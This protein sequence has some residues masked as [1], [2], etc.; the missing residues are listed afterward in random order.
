MA[1]KHHLWIPG[2]ELPLIRPHSLAKHRVIEAYLKRY[3]EVL[4]ANPRQPEFCLTLVDG[5]AGGGLYRDSQTKERRYGSPLLMLHA[6]KEAAQN[7]QKQR[8]KEFHLDVEYFFIEN[9]QGAY[10][11]LAAALQDT[12]FRSL[13]DDKIKLIH[14]E[15]V[16]QV[17]PIVERVEQRG[18][19]KR[20][21]FV[22]DQFGYSDVPMPALR[23]ILSQLDN[24][25]IILTFASDSLINYLS[26][27]ETFQ[28]ILERLGVEISRGTITTL[29]QE[30][31]W[32]RAI[33]DILHREIHQRSE[34]KYYTPFFIRSTDA[35]RDFWLIHL[36]GHARAR[37]VMVG[38]H[39]SE[40][41]SFAHYGRPGLH[42]LGYDP[43]AD[44][45]LTRQ[46]S[47]PV[48]CFDDT[49]RGLSI[50]AL[51]DQLP[52]RISR[53]SDGLPFAEFFA[54]TTNE[55]PATSEIMKEAIATLCREGIV[56]VTD[57]TGI[58]R[59]KVGVQSNSDVLRLSRQKRFITR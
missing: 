20:V 53:H 1:D 45:K 55:T 31:N 19:G 5:F 52:Q 9:D 37:D 13:V 12:E 44:A 23:Q 26:S 8:L 18:R 22:L 48:F 59:R 34:A 47:L 57:K 51:L 41:N 32:R 28:R 39:W 58:K 4:T 46:S 27:N 25:E 15:F 10:Q 36:S 14:G 56:N 43:A 3:V 42:M 7:A 38:L 35:H 11:C 21:I 40:N 2:E 50:D 17:D 30:R 6:M 49:A 29:K 54:A 33:Q 16:S 24:A